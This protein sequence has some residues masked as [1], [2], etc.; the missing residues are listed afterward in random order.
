MASGAAKSAYHSLSGFYF[1]FFASL[2]AFLPYWGL[3]LKSLGFNP[4]AI[5]ELMAVI[6]ITKVIGPNIW[7]WVADHTGRCLLII[8]VTALLAWL[9]FSALLWLVDYGRIMAALAVF[10]FFWNATLPL[11]EMNTLNHLG[12]R[13]HHYSKI[14]LWGSIGFIVS[15]MVL[16]PVF[17]VYGIRILPHIVLALLIGIWLNSMWVRE[18]VN[19]MAKTRRPQLMGTLKQ[20]AVICLLAACMLAQASHGPYYTFFSIYL[21]DLGYSRGLIG[22]LWSL[23]V[24]AEIV[25]FLFMPRWLPRYGARKLFLTALLLT[26]VRWLL[27]AAQA[28]TIAVL[29]IAQVLHAA[30][31]GLYHAT[32]IHMIYRFFPGQLQGRG[33]A[34][35]SSLSFGL[36][37]AIGSLLSGY[38]WTS[39]GGVWIYYMAALLAGL[40]YLI[41][42][43]GIR[44]V[45]ESSDPIF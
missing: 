14:R 36:G 35:Y 16:A 5:G 6:L 9:A 18:G 28:Q 29:L 12:D 10:S 37:G 3:Y 15:V 20:P 8:R 7:G 40:G 23:G 22:M 19:R 2:G 17:D 25:V 27:I 31:F 41:A 24:I 38:V 43:W 1:F 34:L 30:S 45:V 33:Q 26:V 39:L 11:F 44:G 13:V 21:D 42:W 32:A 4:Q